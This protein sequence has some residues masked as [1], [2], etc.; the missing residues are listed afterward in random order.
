MPL[1]TFGVACVVGCAGHAA[2][3]G[4]R[5]APTT[6]VPTT[7]GAPRSLPVVTPSAAEST[8]APPSAKEARGLQ[9][10]LL[11]A[12]GSQV[13]A[14]TAQTTSGDTLDSATLVGNVA[15]VVVFFTSWCPVCES[16]MPVVRNALEAVGSD[17]LV[18]G[19]AMDDEETFGNVP[20]YVERHGIP[21]RVVQGQAA[22]ALVE[23]L[24]PKGSFP[25]RYGVGKD[26]AI[27]DVQIGMKPGHASR[28]EQ[29]LHVALAGSS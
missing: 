22:P 5:P 17:V 9:R 12:R 4:Q 3:V 23:A 2:P 1:A 20:A 27:A 6:P 11:P 21:F 25:V 18:I 13:P 10:L 29:A 7:T 19:V 28:L 14:F 24:D 26:G 8:V 15:F 16:K